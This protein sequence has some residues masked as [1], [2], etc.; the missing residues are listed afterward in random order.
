MTSSNTAREIAR[1]GES[2]LF[3]CHG[4]DAMPNRRLTDD[5]RTALFG[6]LL[7][8]V[9]AR[10]LTLAGTDEQLYW[11]LRRKLSKEL[12]YDERSKPVQRKKLK[13][14][15]RKSQDGKCADCSEPLPE[16]GAVLD[17]TE[18]MLGYTAKN[19]RLLCPTCDERIQGERRYA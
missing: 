19:T 11:A 14:A 18:A 16:R 12:S 9:R 3:A 4:D 2:R 17:R 1:G 10:L 6:P 7:V 5:E 13:L 8:D 15:K